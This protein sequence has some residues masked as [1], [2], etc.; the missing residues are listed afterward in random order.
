MVVLVTA[1]GVTIATIISQLSTE[2]RI[3]VNSWE[4][5]SSSMG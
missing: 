2:A 5:L 4:N 1:G 3:E